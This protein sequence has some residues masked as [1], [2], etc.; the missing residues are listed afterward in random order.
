[1][2]RP[3]EWTDTAADDGSE[4]LDLSGMEVPAW[5]DEA[6]CQDADP[7][8]FFPDKRGS[9]GEAKAVCD[10]CPV[11][12]EC[13]RYALD[14]LGPHD[15]HGVWGGTSRAQRTTMRRERVGAL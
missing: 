8:L 14:E 3:W 9:T 15:D 7:S 12:D 1:M 11:V 2:T 10:A 6:R 13:L 5:Y 4:R